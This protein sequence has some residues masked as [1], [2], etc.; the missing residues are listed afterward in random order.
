MT[1]RLSFDDLAAIT[2]PSD[3]AIS[4]DGRRVCYVL[5][6]VDAD[7]D[8]VR[9]A[10]WLVDADDPRPRRLTAG[11]AD[12]AP[13][14]S[15]DGT[16]LAFLR[17]GDSTCTKDPA[18]V[19]TL[20]MDAPGEPEPLTALPLGA[21]P[22]K[23]SP[24]GGRLAVI[25][26]VD[27]AAGTD[28]SEETAR[29][30]RQRAP[31]VVDR[32][33][34]KADGTGLLGALRS[35]VFVVDAITGQARQVTDGDWDVATVAWHPDGTRLAVTAATAADADLTGT[36][37]IGVVDAADEQAE[38]T[39]AALAD[40]VA[41]AVTW[42]PGGDLLAAGREDT[43]I[44]HLQLLRVT[45]GG[46]DPVDLAAALDRNV[47]PGVPG[48]PGG[49]PHVAADGETVLFCARDRGCTH[50]Y[51]VPAAGG[52]PRKL[53]GEPDSVVG[54]LSVATAAEHAACVVVTPH[55]YGEIVLVDLETGSTRTLTDHTRTAIGDVELVTPEER[56]FVTGDGTEVHGWLLRDPAAPTPAP[57][58]LDVHGGPHNAWSPVPDPGRAYQ[59]VLAARGWA[60]LMVNP[61]AS[62][63]YGEGFFT[64]A[65]GGWGVR[66]QGDLLDPVDALVAEGIADPDRLALH[67]YSYGGFMTCWLTGHTERFA[68]AVAGG[69]VADPVSM[70]TSDLGYELLRLE[71]E[72]LPWTDPQRCATQSPYS[73]VHR[74]RTPTLIL[75]GAADERCP[76][77]QAEQ[78]FAALRAGGVP[79]RMVLYP[80]ASHLFILQGRPT[81]QTDYSRRVVGWV[82][83]Y[84]DGRG[85][86]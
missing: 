84:A 37:P 72:A 59:Q 27:R 78:W 63:G 25:A 38:P 44:G 75:H 30:R 61:R 62:D 64:A 43:Q 12:T 53:V 11:G 40:G 83:E 67:G 68:A 22:P 19:W 21:G 10:L 73:A 85:R 29:T 33:G 24:D 50:L 16:R 86:P 42:L 77:G 47:M 28:E 1:R 70:I 35:H 54:G 46:G 36:L 6:T 57:L 41:A 79:A 15:P 82:S 18:Q 80:G 7:V 55:T 81:H 51:A 8:E 34:Y 32:L 4:P 20:R 76:P 9:R 65:L 69:V 13:R 56:T 60:V 66:D 45:L 49:S 58:L 48:Y 14:W 52:V 31:V 23:W 2:V 5:R 39:T 17:G 3:P 74:V 26:A 71:F